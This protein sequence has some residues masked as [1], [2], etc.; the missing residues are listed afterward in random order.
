MHMQSEAPDFAVFAGHLKVSDLMDG[1]EVWYL[2][3]HLEKE[4]HLRKN[5]DQVLY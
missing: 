5:H 2:R 1:F 4:S 3:I